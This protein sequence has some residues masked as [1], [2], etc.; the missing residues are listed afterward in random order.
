MVFD[1]T[2]MTA[3]SICIFHQRLK[4]VLSAVTVLQSHPPCR[5]VADLGENTA[6]RQQGTISGHWGDPATLECPGFYKQHHPIKMSALV[7]IQGQFP[8]NLSN[9][10]KLR[11]L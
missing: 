8:G 4:D 7:F 6:C 10:Q 5:Y 9:P 3:V 2:F 1:Y 11:L